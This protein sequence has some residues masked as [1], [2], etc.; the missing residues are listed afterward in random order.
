MRL[1]LLLAVA[2]SISLVAYGAERRTGSSYIKKEH[3]KKIVQELDFIELPDGFRISYY[4]RNVP[5]ARGMALGPKGTLFVGSR[6]KGNVYAVQDLDGDHKA[7]K[8]TVVASGFE[9]PVGVAFRDSDLFFSSVS[10]IFRLRDIEDRID[11]P[12]KPEL[13]SDRFPSDRHH[14][15]KF[16]RFGPEGK[17]YVPVGAPCNVCLR[18]D[19]RYA[20]IMR[21]NPDGS[22]LEVYA[23]G[24]RNSVGFDWNPQ[25]DVLWFTDNGRD[26]LGDDLP[27]D[28]LNRAPQ[29]GLHFGFPYW[30]GKVVQDPGF[31]NEHTANEFTLPAQELGAHVASLGMRFYTG[32]MFPKEYQNQIFIAEH[33]SWN[34]SKKVG[35]QI[36]LVRVKDGKALSYEPFATGCLQAG[37]K[38]KG[39][40]VDILNMPDGSLL[41]SDDRSGAI[42]RITYNKFE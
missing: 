31:G 36:S 32:D 40:P 20:T 22:D 13:I 1:A 7:D 25:T 12:P 38:V 14:G 18:D 35:Y 5:N 8:V 10:K 19:L 29:K 39:R 2:L 11:D 3:V 15:W 33:G 28:E 17:L 6:K 41:V 26:M 30:H 4:A 27:P 34:R 42:Y 16:I 21:M 37:E 23:S 9:M 24:I